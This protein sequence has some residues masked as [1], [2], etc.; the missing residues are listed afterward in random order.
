MQK[1][2]KR[3]VVVADLH[4]GGLTG[5]T[6][7]TEQLQTSATG[8]H[9]RN[10]IAE[11]QRE[12][13]SWYVKKVEELQPID[14]AIVNGDSID[15]RGDKSGGT[16]QITTDRNKQCNMAVESLS[17]LRAKDYVMTYGTP[18]HVSS[19]GEDSEDVIRSLLVKEPGVKSV[20]LGSHEWVS[21]NGLVFDIKHKI[22]NSQIPHGRYTA[23]ARDQVWN[24][25]WTLHDEQPRGQV[26]I[27]SHTHYFVYCGNKDWIAMV[28]PAL[29]TMGTK[30]GSRQC[31]G[32]VDFGLVSFDIESDGS[33]SWQ[34]HIA[35]L[36]RHRAQA[37]VL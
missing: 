18:Y 34:V 37:L 6:P 32:T 25:L 20:K 1:R 10:K 12:A 33:Y 23:L 28:T 27:R 30:F 17:M 4:S 36:K 2:R 19:C 29:Q 21:V 26:F 35:E 11:L 13:W 8:G 3:V 24:T 9:W 31:S 22:G 7:P 14:V 5:L 15:G 16:E